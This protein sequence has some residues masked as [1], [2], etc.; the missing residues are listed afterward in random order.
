MSKL[1]KNITT[2]MQD[3]EGLTVV[4]YVVGAGLIVIALAAVFDNLGTLLQ[5]ELDTIFDAAPAADAG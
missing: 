5:G 3:E 4:E 1:I 2:F